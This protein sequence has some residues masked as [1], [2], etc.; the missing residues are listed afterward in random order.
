MNLL[1]DKFNQ[2]VK[3]F[4][5]VKDAGAPM[6]DNIGVYAIPFTRKGLVGYF[7]HKQSSAGRIVSVHRRL[8]DECVK[9]KQVIVLSIYDNYYQFT[10]RQIYESKHYFN[11]YKNAPMINFPLDC[12]KH[13]T[14]TINSVPDLF[15]DNP[16][17][18]ELQKQ[19]NT[20]VVS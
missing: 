17:V 1:T 2:F 7:V 14:V 19:F 5:D 13:I 15:K 11:L 8:Y 4:P 3:L 18:R 16:V 9:N 6:R 20:V 12:G 10:P